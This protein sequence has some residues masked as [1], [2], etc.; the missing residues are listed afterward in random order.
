[1]CAC[2]GIGQMQYST[3]CICSI[4]PLR[5]ANA[6]W[7]GFTMMLSDASKAQTLDA[8][9]GRERAVAEK[10]ASGMTY[11]EI[12][13]ALFIA[14]T[15][16]RTHLATIYEKLGVRNKIGLAAHFAEPSGAQPKGS[17]FV[18]RLAGARHIPDRM[19]E[20]RRA[21]APLCR[22]PVVG[23]HHRPGAIR[24]FARHRLPHDEI[25]GQQ[26]RRFR[27]RRQGARRHLYRVGPV[28]RRRPEGSLDDR[29]CRRTQRRQPVERALRPPGR[30]YFRAAGQPDRKHHQRARRQLRNARHG[31]PQC[32]SPQAAGQPA[33]L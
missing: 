24:G 5:K 8:L 6:S 4:L 30:G 23:H 12:G 26:A 29:A 13:K 16:V 17:I 19:P 31:R 22:R 11:R 10:F 20:F 33:G 21:M 1:M 25:A 7:T 3:S 15:T 32:G 14:P 27:G 2:G 18:R 9:S 28:A